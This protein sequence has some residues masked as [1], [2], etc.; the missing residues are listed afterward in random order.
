MLASQG[1][2]LRTTPLFLVLGQPEGGIEMF[3]AASHWPFQ[4]RFA[5][6]VPDPCLHVYA[7]REAVFVVCG[8]ASLL[9]A[10]AQ[11]RSA[12]DAEGRRAAPPPCLLPEVSPD[13][14]DKLADDEAAVPVP[15]TAAQATAAAAAAPALPR[16]CLIGE[17]KALEPQPQASLWPV[18]DPELTDRLAARLRCLC[19]C[20][21]RDREPLVPINGILVLY[22]FWA[23]DDLHSTRAV[24]QAC[25]K[26]LREVRQSLGTEC[27]VMTLLCDMQRLPGFEAVVAAFPDNSTQQWVLGRDFPLVPDIESARWPGMVEQGIRWL[28]DVLWPSVIYP[29]LQP[30]TGQWSDTDSILQANQQRFQLLQEGW[31]RLKLLPELVVRSL[32]NAPPA[33]PLLGGV[34]LAATGPD[35]LRQQA[36]AA[37]MLRWLVEAQDQ[38]GWTDEA[39]REDALCRRW[40]FWGGLGLAGFLLT[41]VTLSLGLLR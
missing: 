38:V 37:G 23:T 34:G 24:A 32:Q 3:F 6:P 7:N 15:R 8:S 41:L 19:H 17:E 25:R 1:I 26:D 12:D 40:T 21:A 14:T 10:T 20:V 27:P 5:P 31:E 39:L 16:A 36:F 11:R 33:R 2:D 28:A 18:Q 22:P 35:G 30:G 29:L 9:T 4:V 13:A